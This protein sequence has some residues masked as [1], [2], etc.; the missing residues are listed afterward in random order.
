VRIG[1]AAL[2]RCGYVLTVLLLVTVAA[3]FLVD[4]TPGDPAAS[5]LG[6]QASPE[7]VAAVHAQ[8]HLDEPFLSRYWSWLDG[9]LHG[10]L[11][12]S[13]IS[14]Q[15]VREAIGAR[16]PVTVELVMLA[17]G[18]AFLIAVPIGVLTAYRADRFGDRLWSAGSAVLVSLPPFVT[19]LAFVYV[20]ALRDRGV[21]FPATGWTPLAG[22]VAD[23]L[24]HAFLPALTLACGEIPVYARVLRA[25][26][27][28]TLREDYVLAARAKGLGTARVLFRHALRPSSFSLVTLASLSLGRLIGGAVVVEFLFA[29]PGLG[30]LLVV[31]VQGKD[32][33]IVQGVV[34]VIAVAYVLLNTAADGLYG[35]LDPRVRARPA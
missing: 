2:R 23:N 7:R 15:N 16:L 33:V 18:L 8:L 1:L 31:A 12:R 30:Q 5:L 17:V 27:V 21:R 29:L 9:L 34:T 22:G 4:L 20:L 35:V 10:D 11:G 24:W 26:M 14:Q 28:A 19:G 13:L 3:A 25:D 6:D 32:V